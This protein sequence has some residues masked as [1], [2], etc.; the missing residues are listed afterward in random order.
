MVKAICR[1]SEQIHQQTL[2][3]Q[4]ILFC[5]TMNNPL[6]THTE[7]P[8]FRNHCANVNKGT[9]MYNCRI[10]LRQTQVL[11]TVNIVST[12]YSGAFR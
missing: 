10:I 2:T 5:L 8:T 11:D 4:S 1:T 12:R 6:L 9:G 3:D 7:L